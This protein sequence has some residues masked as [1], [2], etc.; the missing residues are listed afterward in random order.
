[1]RW[2]RGH[3]PFYSPK[4]T[5]LERRSGPTAVIYQSDATSR[6]VRGGVRVCSCGERA[7]GG[8]RVAPSETPADALTDNREVSA[9]YGTCRAPDHPSRA[10][11]IGL[12][13]RRTSAV[14]AC[15][16]VRPSTLHGRRATLRTTPSDHRSSPPT[17]SLRI[18]LVR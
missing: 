7:G 11:R 8:V 4:C 17:G 6:S 16:A 5:T 12:P 14:C 9:D 15:R 13:G 3:Q 10:V 1:M 2:S 18:E